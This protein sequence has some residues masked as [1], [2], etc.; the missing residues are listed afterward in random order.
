MKKKLLAV[1]LSVAMLLSIMPMQAIALDATSNAESIFTSGDGTEESPYLISTLA[2]LKAFRDSVNA[3]NT[4]I[5]EYVKLTADIDLNNEEWTPIGTEN[6][7]FK[8]VFDG[9]G[10]TISNL[11]ITKELD[12]VAGNNRLGL[13]GVVGTSF[14]DGSKSTVKNLNIS[15]VSV[16][17]S[18]YVSAIIGTGYCTVEN[19]HIFR[20]INIKGYCYVGGIVGGGYAKINNCSVIDTTEDGGVISGTGSY[21][22]GIQGFTGEDT[23]LIQNCTVKSLAIS[24]TD[25]TGGIVGMSH[26]DVIITDCTVEDLAITISATDGTSGAIAGAVNGTDT[27]LSKL[28]NNTVTDTTVN[29]TETTA[30][31]GGNNSNGNANDNYIVGNNVVLDSS[32]KVVSG[33]FTK[34]TAD[35]LAT[36]LSDISV[37]TENEDGTITVENY[38]AQVND[39]KYFTLKEAIN[40]ANGA[41]VTLLSDVYLTETV[42]IAEDNNVTLDL[43]GKEITVSKS[44]DRS[45][46]AFENKGTF[47]LTDTVGGGSVIARGN[48][49]YGTMIMNGGTVVACDLGGAAIYNNEN[50]KFLMNGG[51]LKVTGVSNYNGDSKGA[52]CIRNM[53]NAETIIK[54]GVFDS[55]CAR[56]YAI[57]SD[58]NENCKLE[59]SPVN[60]EDVKLRAMRG[61]YIGGGTTV[62]NGGVFETFYVSHVDGIYVAYESMPVLSVWGGNSVTVNGGSFTAPDQSVWSAA[63]STPVIINDG[64]FSS[65]TGKAEYYAAK[66]LT[67]YGGT[68]EEDPTEFVAD[69]YAP[70]Q[71][72][73][74]TYGV[75]VADDVAEVNGVKYTSL[76]EA[77]NEANGKTVT[78]LADINL[79][80]GI[81]VEADDEI[82]LDLAGYT[83]S[84]TSDLT[85]G[86]A[87]ITNKGNLTITDSSEN[88]SGKITYSTSSAAT[89]AYA[90]NTITNTATLTILKGTIENTGAYS[91]SLAID[92]NSTAGDA[93]LVIEGGHIVAAWRTIRQFANSETNENNVT[94]SGGIVESLSNRAIW[95]HLP[96]SNTDVENKATLTVRG[97]TVTTEGLSAISVSTYGGSFENA[98]VK[99]SGGTL[100]GEITLNNTEYGGTT[101][102][103]YVTVAITGGTF[104]TNIYGGKGIV[105]KV[106]TEAATDKISVSGG[107]FSTAVAEEYCAEG[108][109]PV[110]NE[111]GTYGVEEKPVETL[112]TKIIMVQGF[113]PNGKKPTEEKYV[114]LLTAG[115]D[116]LNYK[117]AGFNVKLN[118]LDVDF[119]INGKVWEKLN[120]TVNGTEYN[121]TPDWYGEESNYIMYFKVEITDATMA[122]IN[123]DTD[124][125]ITAYA[126]TFDGERIYSDAYTYKV[127]HDGYTNEYYGYGADNNG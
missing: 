52:A 123:A 30:V 19:C 22:G 96:S 71:N 124:I 107:T 48:D 73:D 21:I 43:N 70:V 87:A 115:I 13:F 101:P 80:E 102:E 89:G 24:G 26:K 25:T 7:P 20:D 65:L 109:T 104:T 8:G 69:G 122:T 78:L 116:S 79:A 27:Q 5:K 85:T 37:T 67:I 16:T 99:I 62:I 3:G 36:V 100:N 9:D 11:K 35:Q 120:I 59:I 46:Y 118:N 92:N 63:E 4:Y 33:T 17:G 91:C 39:K 94:V 117:N 14:D 81:L 110:A 112:D 93:N 28:Y 53:E 55:V 54:A 82:I 45:L 49:N 77:I 41:T 119:D 60:S 111:N 68:F 12:N 31:T 83:I 34:A 127:L 76:Q 1:L 32:N 114:L 113:V 10:Y 29:G 86:N 47:T 66:N 61:I 75:A 106:T 105:S 40:N 72:E 84:Y 18:L 56:T 6:N 50:S 125:T 2:E 23:R 51:T 121:I 126:D 38:V 97:G 64:Y 90:T 108:F 57:I 98:D 15:N 88:E 95:M 74:G 44:D 103:D 58:G 42:T